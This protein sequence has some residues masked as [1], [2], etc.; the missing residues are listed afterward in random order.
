MAE[1][2]FVRN[3]TRRHQISNECLP[4]L[5]RRSDFRRNTGPVKYWRVFDIA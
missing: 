5:N 3:A 4:Y 1:I 2:L